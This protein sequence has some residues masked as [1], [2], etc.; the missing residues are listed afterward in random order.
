MTPIHCET[1]EALANNLAFL[2]IDLTDPDFHRLALEHSRATLAG[3][4]DIGIERVVVGAARTGW[5]DPA[6]TLPC[7]D[8]YAAMIDELA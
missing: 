2:E 4:R 6:T 3:Y 7:L 1:P 8:T 5:D